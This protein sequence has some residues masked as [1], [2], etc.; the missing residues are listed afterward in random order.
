[1]N[2]A[3]PFCW[4][5]ILLAAKAEQLDHQVDGRQRLIGEL[6]ALCPNSLDNSPGGDEEGVVPSTGVR[7]QEARG[8]LAA[9]ESPPEYPATPEATVP[10]TL[11]MTG[12]QPGGGRRRS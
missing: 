9:D 5:Q 12:S 1:M 3:P 4:N 8:G 6:S 7:L 10:P 2:C 11:V